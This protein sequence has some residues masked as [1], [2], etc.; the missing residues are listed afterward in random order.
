MGGES[1]GAASNSPAPAPLAT[2]P[3]LIVAEAADQQV[4]GFRKENSRAVSWFH[5]RGGTM[6]ARTALHLRNNLEEYRAETIFVI[7]ER[8]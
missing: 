1:G 6:S 8:R 2:G 4:S 5:V 7:G 3:S